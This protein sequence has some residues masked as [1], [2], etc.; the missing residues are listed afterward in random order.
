ML[1]GSNPTKEILMNRIEVRAGL[2]LIVSLLII[3]CSGCAPS[4]SERRLI[5]GSLRAYEAGKPNRTVLN[6]EHAKIAVFGDSAEARYSICPRTSQFA[7]IP[8]RANLRRL[9]GEWTIVSETRYRP[10]WPFAEQETIPV[11]KDPD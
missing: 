7:F 10:V 3:A 2:I 8:V 6:L 11:S 5:L 1:L 9:S 4:T